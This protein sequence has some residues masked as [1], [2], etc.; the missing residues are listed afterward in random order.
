[1]IKKR[2]GSINKTNILLMFFSF[3]D[4]MLKTFEKEDV[5][6]KFSM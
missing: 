2:H 1:M 6:L 3:K 5:M 4:I